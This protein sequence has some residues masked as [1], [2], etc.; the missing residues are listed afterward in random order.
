MQLAASA[1]ALS[2]IARPARANTYPTRPVRMV[3]GFPASNASDIVARL[4]GQ[5]L[6]ERLDQSF[7]VEN[8]PGAGGNIGV[9]FVVNAA[10]DGYTLL[11]ASTS[12]AI[13]AT[14]YGHLSFNF[15]R[16]IAPV[17]GVARAPYV[18][19]VTPAFP[20]TTIAEFIAYAKANPGKINMASAGNGS[21]SHLCGELFKTMAGID[22]VH[23][24][25][26]TSFLPDLFAGQIQVVF[27]PISQSI[28]YVRSGK[29]RALAVTSAT[30]QP[31]LPDIPAVAEFVPGYEASG[32]YGIGAP[33]NT[34]ADIVASLNTAMN[35][36][37]A[38]ADMKTRLNELGA[39]PMPTTPAEFASFLAADT[40]KWGKV[41]RAADIKPE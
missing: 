30:R 1:S 4:A 31:S 23:V 6:S 9:E 22:M 41:I 8:R 17:A 36:A 13:N 10:P 39:L 16:D 12:A 25:Y 29:L 20:A 18:L 5:N 38:D 35:S 24:P 33:K 27:S 26:R 7:I 21:L 14:L 11:A 37:L 3:V 15:L 28:E 2:S 32:W 19:V 34:P 40:E